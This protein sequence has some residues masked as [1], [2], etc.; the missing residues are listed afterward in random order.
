M[1][2]MQYCRTADEL[3]REYR[4]LE[5]ENHPDIGGDNAKMQEI[6]AE[7]QRLLSRFRFG[8][9]SGA[10]NVYATQAGRKTEE[11]VNQRKPRAKYR[12]SFYSEKAIMDFSSDF[13][14]QGGISYRMPEG[15]TIFYRRG[16]RTVVVK[17]AK[18]TS[19]GERLY[20][21]RQYN[22]CPE[23]YAKAMGI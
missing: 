8:G 22:N 19:S 7:Y 12:K 20:T 4:R 11:S 3:K 15:T 13:I 2:T 16:Y 21:V 17:Y 6:N 10:S 1:T 9:F 23:K 5:K 18:T 14:R